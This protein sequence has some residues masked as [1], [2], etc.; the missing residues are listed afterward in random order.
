[1]SGIASGDR[2]KS[3]AQTEH[4]VAAPRPLAPDLRVGTELAGYAIEEVIGRGGMGIVYRARHKHLERTVA[5]KL[6]LGHVFEGGPEVRRRFVR[7]SRIAASLHH[8]NIVAVYDAGEAEG[9]L[10]LAMQY[11]DGIDLADLIEREGALEPEHALAILGQVADALDVAHGRGLVHRDVKPANVLIDSSRAYLT[12]FGLSRTLSSKSALTRH[13]QF[14]GTIDYM[15]P[16]QISGD[17]VDARTDVYALGCMLFHAL[18]GAL[19]YEQNSQVALIYAHLQDP[20]PSLVSRAPHLP[21]ALDAVVAKAMAKRRDDRFET[22]TALVEAARLAIA[23]E[24]AGPEAATPLRTALIAAGEPGLRA[25][26]SVGLAPRFRTLE[27]ADLDA[28]LA[29]ARRSAPDLV[30]I[31]WALAGGS[32]GQGCSAVRDAVGGTGT[33][34]IALVPRDARLDDPTVRNAGADGSIRTPFSPLQLLYKVGDLLGP[35]V[36]ES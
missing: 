23:G 1:M 22:C 21:L 2:G 27:A 19:P 20:P 13:G 30:L 14:V 28:A 25:T 31:D 4:G 35:E 18:T 15:S 11:V 34:I 5:L 33:T 10:Y 26:A 24:R 6:L 16:E 8:P 7:E 3:P 32:D 17:D 9:H 12:D 36:V 29:I